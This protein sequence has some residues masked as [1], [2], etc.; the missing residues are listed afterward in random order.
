MDEIAWDPGSDRGRR[1]PAGAAAA[2]ARDDAD[3]DAFVA[4]SRTPTYLQTTSWAHVKRLTGWRSVR[5]VASA[6]AGTIGAQMLIARPRFV[7]WA[8]GYVPRGPLTPNGLDRPT[9]AR[10]TDAIQDA[11]RSRRL[12]YVRMEPD[13]EADEAAAEELVLAGWKRAPHVQPV[14]SHVIDLTIGEGRL[15][16][17]LRP[18]C[19]Q[20]VRHARHARVDVVAGGREDLPAFFRILSETAQRCGFPHRTFETYQAVWDAFADS[21]SVE[22]LLAREDGAPSAA[23]F[24]VRCGDRV[25]EPYGGMT[26]AAARSR[27]NYL[28]K[29]EAI[30]RAAAQGMS[31]YDMWG[32]PT[33][34]IGQFKTGFGGRTIT[35]IGAWDLPTSR[36][37][38]TALTLGQGLRDRWV[39]WRYPRRRSGGPPHAGPDG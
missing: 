35:Y 13:M 36:V 20:Y 31:S 15:W 21:G 11:A 29:W 32:L 19:R 12:A 5:V 26:S 1:G 23:L 24:L 38:C 18:K 3:W 28:L 22:L 9:T 7:P 10:F 17:G 16:D 37:G 2:L 4:A 25:T 34:G 6:A 30:R 27:A 14:S 8:V 39:D 33:S